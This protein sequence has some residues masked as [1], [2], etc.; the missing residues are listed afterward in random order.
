MDSDRLL[1]VVVAHSRPS[2]LQQVL[3]QLQIVLD[4]R[5]Y[6]IND[7]EV[8]AYIDGER[9]QKEKVLVEQCQR[10]VENQGFGYIRRPQ[11]L[12]LRQNILG[13]LEEIREAPNSKFI[14]LEDDIIISQAGFDF[15]VY[16]L[17]NHSALASNAV[18][19]SSF[20]P[21]SKYP[22]HSFAFPRVSTWGWGGWTKKIP[23]R[24]L[25]EANW[26]E[27]DIS[28][29]A[30]KYKE[31]LKYMPDIVHL[32]NLQKQGEIN[33]W[34]LD[35]LIY[36]L[37]NNCI[38][39]YPSISLSQNIGHDGTGTNCGNDRSKSVKYVHRDFDL[40]IKSIPFVSDR[41][42]NYFPHFRACYSPN[43]VDRLTKK[44]CWR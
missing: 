44:V 43:I 35:F 38:T 13:V 26:S 24:K 39:I 28:S 2:H 7:V 3:D 14:L 36:M 8:R 16:C 34:S 9:N 19:V 11:N 22:F 37:D 18:Q 42:H 6:T 40:N 25:L 30:A 21:V 20:S 31:I 23:A 5:G 29:F 15:L 32:M 41:I 17:D 4:A 33:S 10:V 12:G 27:F 1:I